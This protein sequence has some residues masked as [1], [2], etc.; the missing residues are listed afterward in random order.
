MHLHS[1]PRNRF[2]SWGLKCGT[3]DSGVQHDHPDDGALEPENSG[4]EGGEGGGGYVGS[5]HLAPETA[6]KARFDRQKTA[7]RFGSVIFDTPY[8]TA[9]SGA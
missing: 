9:L 5:P 4:G 8:F 7:N 1:D 2:H 6:G 3:V